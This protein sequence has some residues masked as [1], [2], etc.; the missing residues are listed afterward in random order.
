MYESSDPS[1]LL[2]RNVVRNSSPIQAQL[3]DPMPLLLAAVGAA[4]ESRV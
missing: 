3:S 4:G 1:E 2:D